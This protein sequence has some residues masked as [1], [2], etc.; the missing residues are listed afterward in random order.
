MKNKMEEMI[1]TFNQLN[2]SDFCLTLK[3]RIPS[4]S[5]ATEI[6]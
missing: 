1:N 2:S 3:D 5:F 4:P 6:I